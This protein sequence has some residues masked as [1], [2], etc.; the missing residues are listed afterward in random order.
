MVASTSKVSGRLAR[1]AAADDAAEGDRVARLDWTARGDVL[2]TICRHGDIESLVMLMVTTVVRRAGIREDAI[3]NAIVLTHV[4]DAVGGGDR[5]IRRVS[6]VAENRG[7]SNI[8]NVIAEAAAVR[9][10]TRDGAIIEEAGLDRARQSIAAE[11]A[12][13]A[14]AFVIRIRRV[15]RATARETGRVGREI[16]FDQVRNKNPDKIGAIIF[17]RCH[18]TAEEDLIDQLRQLRRRSVLLEKGRIRSRLRAAV[19][20]LV[21]DRDE[22]FVEQRI[23]LASDLDER[24]GINRRLRTLTFGQDPRGLAISRRVD[25]YH[26]LVATKVADRD[27]EHH[28][29]SVEASLAIEDVIA[30][31]EI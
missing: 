12:E 25:T 29:M 28:R 23:S 1:A 7:D 13:T 27:L 9:P 8:N 18:L 3:V 26:L 19:K 21:H 16:D 24:T 15:T 6:Q 11:N 20:I 22:R 4:I 5:R 31:A 14:E 10:A 17:E 2:E 30:R